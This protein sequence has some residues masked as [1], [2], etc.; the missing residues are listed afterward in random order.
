MEEQGAQELSRTEL[1]ALVME[2]RAEIA[3]LKTRLATLET[4]L[5]QARKNSRNS[6]KPPS[7]DIVKPPRP[8]PVSGHNHI[9]AQ[10]GHE[11]HER[12]PFPPEKVNRH[13]DHKPCTCPDCGGPVRCGV[14]PSLITQQVELVAKPF[15]V[16]EHRAW[17]GQCTRCGRKVYAA[18]PPEVEHAGLFGPRLTAHVAWLKLR[19]HVSYSGIQEYLRDVLGLDVSRGYL[20]KVFQKAAAALRPAWTELHGALRDQPVLNADETS[21]PEAGKRRWTWVF[22]AAFFTVFLIAPS[23]GS[24]V[25]VRTLGKAFAG[26]LCADY[27]SAYRKYMGEHNVLV[28]F[29]M[30]H[31]IRDARFLAE[32]RDPVTRRYGQKVVQRPRQLFRVIHC[33]ERYASPEVFQ[34]ALE[35]ARDRL[36]A[37]VLRAPARREAQ[38]LAKRFRQ[39]GEAYL[40]FVT[41]PGLEPTNNLA[42]QALRFVVLDRRITQGTRSAKGSTARETLWTIAAT[43]RQQGR[44]LYHYLVEAISAHFAER[45]I[46]SLLPAGP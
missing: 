2:Q 32:L 36:R 37:T 11:R 1:L 17:D 45:L 5:A 14:E 3:A 34:R 42:E 46:P 6:S 39:H 20:D 29:C 19:G 41:T 31:L 38:N 16:T 8:G 23:R 18:L 9:G 30:A 26:I 28:Q 15:K 40:L 4:E 22:R 44:S 10:P 7:S 13:K 27:F 24:E 25:L 35:R 21:H 33:R 12:A 43:C